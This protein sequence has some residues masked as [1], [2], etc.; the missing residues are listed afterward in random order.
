VDNATF[1]NRDFYYES[2][3]EESYS[4]IGLVQKDLIFNFLE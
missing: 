2:S 4:D 3:S 1:D